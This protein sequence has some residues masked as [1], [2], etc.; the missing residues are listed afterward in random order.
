MAENQQLIVLTPGQ[1]Q[2]FFRDELLPLL[3]ESIQAQP[4]QPALLDKR[5]LAEALCISK[6]TIDRQVKRGL[7]YV[8]LGD[9]KRF[10]LAAC[11]AWLR[12]Q[13]GEPT[14]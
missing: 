7:P 13:T 3:V 9:S 5:R 14:P 10:D 1:L 4:E 12:A 6:S 11:V 2:A 8:R